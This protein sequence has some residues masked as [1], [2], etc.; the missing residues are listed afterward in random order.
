MVSGTRSQLDRKITYHSS[1]GENTDEKP[2]SIL[3]AWKSVESKRKLSATPSV[4]P[5]RNLSEKR[6]RWE[7]GVLRRYA[8]AVFTLIFENSPIWLLSLEPYFVKELWFPQFASFS[9]LRKRIVDAGKLF[10]ELL[11]KFDISILKFNGKSVSDN[12]LCDSGIL[13][14][15][16]S[17]TF[18]KETVIQRLYSFTSPGIFIVDTHCRMRKLPDFRMS[19]SRVKHS[20][21]GGATKFETVFACLNASVVPPDSQLK[22]DIG[23]FLDFSRYARPCGEEDVGEMITQYDLLPISDHAFSG[24]I[25]VESRLSSS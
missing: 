18:A 25:I 2:S 8:P 16:G 1:G 14:V 17:L 22:R 9:D 21:C 3:S 10:V 15:S 7:T 12:S 11:F 19:L 5:Y 23:V 4:G 13:L 20:Q 6:K 24:E